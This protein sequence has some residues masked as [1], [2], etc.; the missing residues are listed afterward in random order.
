MV[1]AAFIVEYIWRIVI[2][3]VMV[4]AFLDFVV[5]NSEGRATG[6]LLL[7]TFAVWV[8]AVLAG[9]LAANAV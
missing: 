7:G 2:G 3:V 5:L 4:G 6:L 9:M 8:L 1:V